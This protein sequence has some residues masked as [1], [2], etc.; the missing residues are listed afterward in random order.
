MEM[1]PVKRTTAQTVGNNFMTCISLFYVNFPSDA[2]AFPVVK[3]NFR[4]TS[5]SG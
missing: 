5:G 4:H 3:N 2:T 1:K